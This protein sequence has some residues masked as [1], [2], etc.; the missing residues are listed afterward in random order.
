MS[1]REDVRKFLKEFQEKMGFWDVLFLDDRGKNSQTLADIEIRPIERKKV[2]NSLEIEDYSEGPLEERWHGA[3]EMW[4]FGKL[5]KKHEIYI[6]I[7]MG[8]PGKNV[9][10]ISFHVAEHKMNYPLKKQ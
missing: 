1:T 8:L 3:A 7:S 9:N 4:V 5:I 10:C 2:L 6:K